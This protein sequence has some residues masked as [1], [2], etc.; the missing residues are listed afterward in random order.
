MT[1]NVLGGCCLLQIMYSK[2]RFSNCPIIIMQLQNNNCNCRL[3]VVNFFLH[4]IVHSSG[5]TIQEGNHLFNAMSSNSK[6]RSVSSYK[7]DHMRIYLSCAILDWLEMKRVDIFRTCP[8]FQKWNEVLCWKNEME[9]LNILI[10]MQYSISSQ[11]KWS[12]LM[13]SNKSIMI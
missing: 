11:T 1:D 3:Q 2:S 6:S 9:S 4:S 7:L 10:W 12:L 5:T 13:I 8:P